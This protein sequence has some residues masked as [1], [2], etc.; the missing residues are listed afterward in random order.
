MKQVHVQMKMMSKHATGVRLIVN[1][2][3]QL[4]KKRRMGRQA[5]I[6]RLIVNELRQL[7]QKRL[8]NKQATVVRLI[9]TALR[10]LEKVRPMLKLERNVSVTT[11]RREAL[12]KSMIFNWL[13][14]LQRYKGV[15][16]LIA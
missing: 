15:A 11:I 3:R 8:M 10:Q 12:R 14:Q 1:S 5:T 4:G 9:V 7:E 13:G 6:V 16:L 2:L